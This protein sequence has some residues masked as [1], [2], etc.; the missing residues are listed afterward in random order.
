MTNSKSQS[1]F[2][3]SELLVGVSIASIGL[4]AMM[5]MMQ[6]SSK[7]QS[8]NNLT[9][10]ADSFR[11]SLVSAVNNSSGWKNTF[12]NSANNQANLSFLDCLVGST[13]PCTAD[14]TTDVGAG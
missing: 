4:A 6:I 3:I 8:Q 12:K 5:S 7:Q 1:G 13:T 9:Y 14:E 11:R 2:S 10:Q